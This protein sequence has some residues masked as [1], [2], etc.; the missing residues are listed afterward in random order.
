MACDVEEAGK[1]EKVILELLIQRCIFFQK[2]EGLRKER[3]GKRLVL[4]CL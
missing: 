1:E 4:V 2:P 3:L